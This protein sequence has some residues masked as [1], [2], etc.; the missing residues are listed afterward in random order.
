MS[1][2]AQ[3]G[4]NGG[5]QSQVLAVMSGKWPPILV[6]GFWRKAL[7]GTKFLVL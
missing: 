4:D 2:K 5:V 1:D 3:W 6:H 7:A